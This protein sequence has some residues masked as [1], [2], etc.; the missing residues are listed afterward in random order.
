MCATLFVFGKRQSRMLA[1]TST[2]GLQW[3]CRLLFITDRATKQQFLV[4]FTQSLHAHVGR[5]T[6]ML[7]AANGTTI[8]TYGNRVGYRTGPTHHV[9]V[10]SGK[11]P[12]TNFRCWLL[13]EPTNS[14]RPQQHQIRLVD[15]TTF[16][17][18]IPTVS[19]P[20]Y[21]Q[22]RCLAPA[23]LAV[24]KRAFLEMESMGIVYLSSSPWASP[25]HMVPKK[26][27]QWRPCG[28]YRR[29]N[30]ATKPDRYPITHIQDFTATLAGKTVFSKIDLVRAYN[31]I[32]MAPQDVP[33]KAV[34]TPFGLSEFCARLTA[35]AMPHRLSNASLTTSAGASILCTLIWT[36]CLLPALQKKS[37]GSTC[38]NCSSAYK[39]MVWL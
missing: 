15:S 32:S 8:R 13:Q 1:A 27:R 2:S 14:H 4:L 37:M 34:I 11:R 36:I 20:V 33:K 23:Q 3:S 7:A 5:A 21:A 9:D 16:D 10:Y 39:T 38:T 18:H 24:A 22:A 6:T 31:Q 17:H 19:P 29:L 28:D 26:N 30:A 12:T 25:M 35:F